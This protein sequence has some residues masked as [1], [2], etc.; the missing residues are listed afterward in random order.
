MIDLKGKKI[1]VTGA[2]SGIGK[3]VAL[4]I[5]KL[6]ADVIIT[7]RNLDALKDTASRVVTNCEFITCDLAEESEIEHFSKQVG[8]ID[9]LAHCAGIVQPFPIKYIK[10]KH[11]DAVMKINLFSGILL[12]SN[13][14]RNKSFNN[15]SSV[16]FISS[17]S[18]DHPYNGS[19][20]YS[21]S[22]KGLEA[23]ARSFSLEQATKKM[24][25]NVVSPALVK[26]AIFDQ[27]KDAYDKEYVE[28]IEGQYPLGI[29]EPLDVAQMIA[30]L[31]SDNSKWITGTTIKMDGG[32]L[33]NT[34]I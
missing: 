9:G 8:S 26:T 2:S 7:G 18:A 12:C 20:L 14:L 5:S 25:A 33:L 22:K 30:F 29:G 28:H 10:A 34:K 17:V 3:E 27:T 15:G 6:G 32:L 13:L 16:I 19:A 11:I 1:V 23:F 24:R 4:L 31:L 21:V